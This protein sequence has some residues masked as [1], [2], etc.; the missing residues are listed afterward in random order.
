MKKIIFSLILSSTFAIS[1]VAQTSS[2]LPDW[3]ELH[4]KMVRQAKGIS[5][6]AYSRHFAYTAIACYESVVGGNTS[7]IP[8]ANQLNGSPVMPAR[9]G[10]EVYWPAALN[11]AYADM[12]RHFYSSFGNCKA[13]IDSME[14]DKRYQFTRL[15]A[16]SGDLD[17]S[18][19][20][21]RA[22]SA[23]VLKWA[24]GDGSEMNNKKQY[25]P[26]KGD[27][28][29]IPNPTA[30]APFWYENR[31]MTK[32]L[33][34]V[35]LL[36]PPVYSGEKATDFYK[37]ANEVYSVSKEGDTEK[38]AIALFWDDSPNGQYMTVF[39]H[40][41]SILSQL[42][43]KHNFSMMKAAEAYA[44]MTIAMYDA[45]LLVWK[46][47]YQYNVVR[48]ITYIQQHINKQWTPLISTPTHPEFPAA[49][50]TLSNAAAIALC[51]SFGE[52]CS[53]IDNSYMDIG[54]KERSFLTLQDAAREAGMSR[55]YGGIHYRYSIEQGLLLGG[56]AAKHADAMVKYKR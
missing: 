41:T 28:V 9:P 43:R 14:E 27:G 26:S 11:A 20:Y 3:M 2:L 39:G 35:Y 54:M 37:M 7:Y 33:F 34:S 48:P 52:N 13:T 29:W 40:W 46:G 4:S 24:G 38:K 25:A 47:K 42:I 36:T 51:V 22:I 10:G 5:H 16:S 30:A 53:V 19:Q 1:G 21:G 12:L 17:K 18:A 23:A 15:G 6:V 50:A 8:I 44:R 32:D 45:C 31:S 49:H 55:L 56:A